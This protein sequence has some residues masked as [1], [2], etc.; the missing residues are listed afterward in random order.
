MP[1][2]PKP[3]PF[4]P[5]R[6]CLDLGAGGFGASGGG[7]VSGGGAPAATACGGT[8]PLAVFCTSASLLGGASARVGAPMFAWLLGL[9]AH[10][11]P[12]LPPPGLPRKR[13]HAVRGLGALRSPLQQWRLGLQRKQRPAAQGAKVTAPATEPIAT[14]AA[15]PAAPPAS[16]HALRRDQPRVPLHGKYP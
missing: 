16:S 6:S 15:A 10:P 7:C 12:A 14:L 1:R 5:A 9:V 13:R 8:P 3:V 2:A 4:S 11:L